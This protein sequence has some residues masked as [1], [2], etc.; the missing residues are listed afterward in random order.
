M[1]MITR[2]AAAATKPDVNIT[3]TGNKYKVEQLSSFKNI[4]VEFNLGEQYEAD[5]GTGKNTYITTVDGAK[6]ITKVASTGK[7]AAVREF[8]DAGFVMTIYSDNVTAIRTF[9]RA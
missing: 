6:M 8:N 2:K 7:T 9:K 3:I 1:G 5:P 4:T